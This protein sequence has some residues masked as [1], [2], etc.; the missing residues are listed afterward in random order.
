MGFFTPPE[1][2]YIMLH[3]FVQGESPEKVHQRIKEYRK[4]EKQVQMFDK[5][6]KK[7]KEN[8]ND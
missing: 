5:A 3:F 2:R 8:K 4:F 6:D 1:E 7:D